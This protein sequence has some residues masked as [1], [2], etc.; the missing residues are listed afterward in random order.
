MSTR[1]ERELYGQMSIFDF[2]SNTCVVP[3]NT[4][5]DNIIKNVLR[6]GG[7]DR[8][9]LLRITAALIENLD[10][11][12]L[13]KFLEHEY[14]K[15]GKGFTF[16]N[17]KIAIWF[18]SDGVKFKKGSRTID[19]V[20]RIVTWIE[21]AEMI[22]EMYQ[23]GCFCTKDITENAIE[24]EISEMTEFLSFHLSDAARDDNSLKIIKDYINSSYGCYKLRKTVREDLGN[25]PSVLIDILEALEEDITINPELYHGWV[26]R[27]NGSYLLRVKNLSREK[28]WIPQNYNEDL[29]K[30]SFIT[31]DE[32]D[33]DLGR[34]SGFSGGKERICKFFLEEH[35]KTEQAEFLKHEYGIGGRSHVLGHDSFN[36]NYDAK[37]IQLDKGDILSPEISILI[38]WP[39]VADRIRNMI[40]QNRY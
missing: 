19:D 30:L 12:S 26:R 25:N 34:G 15:G 21:A 40:K 36:E 31:D 1:K 29:P 22:H 28:V 20:D 13:A 14:Q 2:I 11:E 9:T 37:G 3:E 38:K 10:N 24:N 33:G 5:K 16:D 39:E 35:T 18:D 27:N 7:C 4:I 17:E 8:N 6:T 23:N 32:I